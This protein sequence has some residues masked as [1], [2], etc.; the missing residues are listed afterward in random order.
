MTTSNS[1]LTLNGNS[2]SNTLTGGA[3]NDQINGRGGDD[4]L[5]GGAGNDEINGGAGNDILDGGSGSD[6]LEGGSG[7]DTLIYKLAENNVKGTHDEYDGGSGTDTLELQFTR[8]EWMN[9]SN[10]TVLQS[11]LNWASK[12]GSN[13]HW[14]DEFTFKFANAK[15]EIEDIEKLVVKVDNQVIN[16]AGN[17]IVFAHNDAIIITEDEMGVQAIHVLDN[18]NVNDLVKSLEL[19]TNLINGTV[20]LIKPDVDNA[21]TWYFNYTPDS[22]YYQH[23]NTGMMATEFFTYKVTDANG[24]YD[25]AIVSVNIRG[26]NDKAVIDGVISGEVTE[27]GSSNNGGTPTATGQLTA[28]DVDNAPNTFVVVE[29]QASTFGTFSIT[30]GGLWTYTLNNSNRAVETLSSESDLLP[31]SFKIHSIDGTEQTISINIKGADD[32]INSKPVVDE[33]VHGQISYAGSANVTELINLDYSNPIIAAKAALGGDYDYKHVRTGQFFVSDKDASDAITLLSTAKGGSDYLGE[34]TASIS[35]QKNVD[36]KYLVT[37]KYEANDSILNPLNKNIDGSAS[38]DQTYTLTFKSGADT[39]STK[40]NLHLYGQDEIQFSD[41][42][43][44][45]NVYVGSDGPDSKLSNPGNDVLYMG[46]GFDTITLADGND[47]AYGGDQSVQIFNLENGSP[48]VFKNSYGQINIAPEVE[49]GIVIDKD[50]DQFFELFSNVSN[51]NSNNNRTTHIWAGEGID[52]FFQHALIPNKQTQD[53][54]MDFNGYSAYAGVGDRI[55][56]ENF[57]NIP[58]YIGHI[59]DPNFTKLKE[60]HADAS[61]AFLS[62]GTKYYELIVVDPTNQNEYSVFNLVGTDITVQSLFDNGN[63]Y[64]VNA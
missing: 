58:S 28:A 23:L 54:I 38:K 7:N 26:V 17:N 57:L 50:K 61:D 19:S 10:Q 59:W 21:S 18:D 12:S 34:F 46:E 43:A 13:C 53:W 48:V 24:D 63:L 55:E 30:S 1:N 51:S 45:N 44:E 41:V 31:D 42:D 56:F 39:V 35:N 8:A 62:E 40:V 3:G 15:L 49:N 52:D 4:V 33:I 25:S 29:N 64:S 37:W 20:S 11:Y 6:E 14:D 9:A 60:H 16:N 27:S 36:G 32:V 22:H 47:I 5:S 2:G